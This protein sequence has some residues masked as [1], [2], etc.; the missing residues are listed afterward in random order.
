MLLMAL[1]EAE[2]AADAA[3]VARI[4]AIAEELER[5]QPVDWDE[6]LA[7]GGGPAL[8]LGAERRSNPR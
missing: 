1:P 2:N 3:L 8:A 6:D 4:Q 7:R 5:L